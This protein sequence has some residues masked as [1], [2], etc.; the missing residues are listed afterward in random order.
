MFASAALILAACTPMQWHKPGVDDAALARET[1]ACRR[2]AREQ[3][4]HE[5][6]ARVLSQPY[7]T[8]L[9]PRGH[10]TLAPPLAAEGDRVIIEQTLM[11]NCMRSLGYVL[12]PQPGHH[13]R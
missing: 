3:S 11:S 1:D 8:G 4:F 7:G 10:A 12:A 2:Q 9:D 5:L 6:N 13:A